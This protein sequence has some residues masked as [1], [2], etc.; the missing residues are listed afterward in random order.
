MWLHGF[1]LQALFISGNVYWPMITHWEYLEGAS[2][3]AGM[4]AWLACVV[5]VLGTQLRRLLTRPALLRGFNVSMAL[6]LVLTLIPVW[7]A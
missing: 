4:I 7:L 3:L 2:N 1:L 6:L 5:L